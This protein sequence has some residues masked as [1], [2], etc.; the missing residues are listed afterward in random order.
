MSSLITSLTLNLKKRH[1]DSVWGRGV[2][3]TSFTALS[4]S[5]SNKNSAEGYIVPGNDHVSMTCKVNFDNCNSYSYEFL[6]SAHSLMMFYICA[7]IGENISKG[8]QGY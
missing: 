6:I 5:D 4:Y 2:H 7:K 3:S 1:L 8:F